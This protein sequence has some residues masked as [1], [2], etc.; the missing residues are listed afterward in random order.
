MTKPLTQAQLEA[1]LRRLNFA[2]LPI[3][4]VEPDRLVEWASYQRVLLAAGINP[5][6]LEWDGER[7]TADDVYVRWMSPNIKAWHHLHETVPGFPPLRLATW[8]PTFALGSALRSMFGLSHRQV[9][10][11]KYMRYEVDLARLELRRR[12]LKAKEQHDR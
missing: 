3:G 4:E 2:R 8:S 1:Q 7:Y 9:G 10:S 12:L 5:V 11:H 6:T